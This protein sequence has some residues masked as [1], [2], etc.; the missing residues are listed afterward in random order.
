VV[1]KLFG[2]LVNCCS[3]RKFRNA[4]SNLTLLNLIAST[5]DDVEVLE[6]DDDYY[7]FLNLPRNVSL[8]I[9]LV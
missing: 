4:Q 7:A 2:E 8:S 3:T 5:M 1:N 9:H 6:A